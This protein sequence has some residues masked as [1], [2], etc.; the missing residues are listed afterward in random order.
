M[1]INDDTV[2]SRLQKA[3][4]PKAKKLPQPIAKVSEK[5]KKEQA[6]EKKVTAMDKEFYLERW[7]SAPHKCEECGKGLGREPLTIFFH[8]LLEKRNYPEFRYIPEN[9]MILCPDHHAQA[10]TDIDKVPKVK[11]RRE[12]VAKALLK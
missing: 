1:S 4:E 6:E 9:I 12:Q 10:E 2:L 7:V 3:R 11:T 5:K 8:H